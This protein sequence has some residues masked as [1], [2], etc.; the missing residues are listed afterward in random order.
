MDA[1]FLLVYSSRNASNVVQ[2]F[3]VTVSST[4]LRTILDKFGCPPEFRNLLK[5][6]QN[7]MKDYCTFEGTLSYPICIDNGVQQGDIDV[8]TTF[9]YITRFPGP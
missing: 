3:K 2:L 6:P 1:S 7:D 4:I 5:Q 9:P 8:P